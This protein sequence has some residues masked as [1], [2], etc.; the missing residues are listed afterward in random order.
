MSYYA[1]HEIKTAEAM[2]YLRKIFPDAQADENN[3][4]IFSTSGVHG[5]YSTIEDCEVNPNDTVTF[6]ILKPRIV[7]TCYGNCRPETPNDIA[8]LK[9]LRETSRAILRSI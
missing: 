2:E 5:S 7:Q 6:L 1:T 9:K 3:F 8:F 4:A